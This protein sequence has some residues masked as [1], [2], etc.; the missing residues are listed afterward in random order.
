MAFDLKN[1]MTVNER[2]KVFKEQY[3]NWNIETEMIDFARPKG[4]YTDK[5]G[6]AESN[7]GYVYYKAIIKDEDGKIKATGSAFEV[8]SWTNGKMAINDRSYIENCETSAVGRALAFLGIGIDGGISSFEEF[9]NAMQQKDRYEIYN[10]MFISNQDA[11]DIVRLAIN[12]L[13]IQCGIRKGLLDEKV[14]ERTW[15]ELKELDLNQLLRLE[16]ELRKVNRE[17]SEWHDLY[18]SNSKI[19]NI[20]DKNI[21]INYKSSHYR[22]GK[23][24]LELAKDDELLKGNIINQYAELGFDLTNED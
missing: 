19:K 1:Y 15:T 13:T 10:D 21:T 9:M 22:F 20:V 16:K 4:I 5:S 11:V 2:V 18:G 23:K 8:Q 7:D 12:D 24:A 6:V 3:P 14:K 17:T